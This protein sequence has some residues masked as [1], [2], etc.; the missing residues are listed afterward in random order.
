[1]NT[2]TSPG[3]LNDETLREHHGIYFYLK[4]QSF[5]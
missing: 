5:T 1:M 4:C 2:D 3:I